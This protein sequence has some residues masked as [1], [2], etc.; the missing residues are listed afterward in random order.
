MN[1]Y[2]VFIS[3]SH[4]DQDLALKIVE[5]IKKN[6]LTPMWDKDFLFGHGFQDSIK[7][8]IAHAHVFLPI[9]TESS[10]KRG[11]V[12]QEIGYAMA[13]NVPVLPLTLG[14]LPGEMIRELQ[15]IQLKDLDE[16]KDKLSREIFD[17]LVKSYQRAQ[18]ALFQCAEHAEDRAIMMTRYANDL[19]QLKHVLQLGAYG[20][21]RQKG[22][23]S[24][25]HI[26]KEVVSHH[27][28]MER[29]DTK[30]QRSEYYHKHLREE[31]LSLEEHAQVKGCRLI[32]NPYL[33]Y[34]IYGF[35]ARIAR[36]KTLVEFLEHMPDDKV[37]VA[38]NRRMLNENQ[39][40]VGDWF[41]AESVSASPGRGY[42]QT[43]FTR[44]APSI[45]EKIE[46]FDH[47]FKELL[48]SSGW[49]S[50]SSK[51]EAVNTIKEIIVDLKSKSKG[52]ASVVEFENR[53]DRKHE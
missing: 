35:G 51:G 44:H 34:K 32:I 17:N 22:A 45:Q 50:A 11:W 16:L 13:L 49:K 29:Y 41:A 52:Q 9:I 14:T 27:I 36:L 12:H 53:K 28:W 18:F 8:F 2:R 30:H 39:T 15:A 7:T 47:E 48:Q 19:L 4:E 26:P 33:T 1:P 3:Y 38:I 6:G 43:I 37:Q 31:R 21:V 20:C 5:V 40:I 42:L 23:L 25:F 24:S 46:L 10:S